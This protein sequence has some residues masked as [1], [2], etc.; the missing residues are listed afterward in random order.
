M[1]SRPAGQEKLSKKD[2]K[3]LARELARMEREREAQR[4]RRKRRLA[5]AGTGTAVVVV[6]VV[7]ALIV[8]AS[9]QAGHVGPKNMR[10][11]G[12]VFT[13]T[14][15][16][17]AVTANRTTALDPGEPPTPTPVDRQNN[18]DVVVYADYRSPDAAT[19][20]AANSAAIG[21]W[22]TAGLASLEV[23]PLALLDGTEVDVQPPVSPS[24]SPSPTPSPAPSA[25]PTR[26]QTTG[27]YSARAAGALACV[28]DTVPDGGLA[29][30]NALLAAQP[31]LT[32]SGLN[33][34][35]LVALV[36]GAGVTD[37]RVADCITRG[38]FTDWVREATDRAAASVPYDI[39]SVTTSPVVLIGGREYTG[40]LDDPEALKAFVE[41]V[42]MDLAAEAA[43]D[44][45]ASPTAEPSASPSGAPSAT[46]STTPTAEAG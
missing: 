37:E 35:D 40:A 39:G 19:F 26:M 34:D 43:A 10:S 15:N 41:Q 38:G 5:W 23:H 21:G 31:E 4:K 18:L 45:S 28:A 3:A 33:D 42:G 12:L 6:G 27:D 32:A 16:G 29:V 44:A 1:S 46:P 20:W 13:G 14:G 24:P 22:V 36:R 8:H 30:H 7:T 17:N 9:V 11:D 25:A 2:R